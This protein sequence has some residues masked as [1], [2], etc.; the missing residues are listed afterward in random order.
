MSTVSLP[1]QVPVSSGSS[2]SPSPP[3][4]HQRGLS[5]LVLLGPSKLRRRRRARQHP[6]ASPL[7]FF[8]LLDERTRQ[9]APALTPSNQERQEP[10]R[11]DYIPL[12][13]SLLADSVSS[14]L[15]F[16]WVSASGAFFHVPFQALEGSDSTDSPAV[17]TAKS[18]AS[19]TSGKRLES[20]FER[21]SF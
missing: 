11:L 14:L 18:G 8:S 16:D 17:A 7:P 4:L 21:A 15:A 5:R 1:G 10:G 6:R 13:F 20:R 3:P 12:P 9:D 2:S 19:R